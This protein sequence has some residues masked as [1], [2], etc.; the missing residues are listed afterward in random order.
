MAD[1]RRPRVRF[2]AGPADFVRSSVSPLDIEH[3]NPD[4]HTEE[5]ER[6]DA[7]H[8]ERASLLQVNQLEQQF[9]LIYEEGKQ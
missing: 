9:N 2:E 5:L 6:V 7:E 8:R 3:F 1:I 4:I